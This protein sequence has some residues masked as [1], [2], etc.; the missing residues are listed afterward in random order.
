MGK[1]KKVIK[2]TSMGEDYKAVKWKLTLKE[3]EKRWYS[4]EDKL[5]SPDDILL[6]CKIGGV[7]IYVRRFSDLLEIL[8][9]CYEDEYTDYG[10]LENILDGTSFDNRLKCMYNNDCECDCKDNAYDRAEAMSDIRDELL[11]NSVEYLVRKY[12]KQEIIERFYRPVYYTV[13]LPKATKKEIIEAVKK[14]IEL[15]EE[16]EE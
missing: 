10:L 9:I 7:K 15:Y 6:Q 3:L 16:G 1:N 4:E 14:S 5:P 13:P 2:F 11:N 8:G 12:T